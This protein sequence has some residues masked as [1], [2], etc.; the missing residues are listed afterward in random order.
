M[1]GAI[2]SAVPDTEQVGYPWSAGRQ[3]LS[4]M[5]PWVLP[6]GKGKTRRFPRRTGSLTTTA[7]PLRPPSTWENSRPPSR[8]WAVGGAH[9]VLHGL[10]Q[11]EAPIAECSRAR[12]SGSGRGPTSTASSGLSPRRL[13]WIGEAAEGRTRVAVPEQAVRPPALSTCAAWV[14][15]GAIIGD[16]WWTKGVKGVGSTGARRQRGW[17]LRTGG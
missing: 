16:M 7:S 2:R 9:A 11:I 14:G 13:T 1:R 10:P 6:C 3:Q 17:I 15:S 8:P 12:Y 4:S 5:H